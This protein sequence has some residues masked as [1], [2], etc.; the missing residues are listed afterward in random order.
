LGGVVPGAGE[1]EEDPEHVDQPD[2]QMLVVGA[3]AD[4]GDLADEPDQPT[5]GEQQG[6]H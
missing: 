4:G 1:A 6:G 5:G 2:G 3:E